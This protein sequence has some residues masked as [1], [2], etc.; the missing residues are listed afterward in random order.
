[1]NHVQRS[2][3][4]LLS[5][6]AC[7][8]LTGCSSAD[9]SSGDATGAAKVGTSGPTIAPLDLSQDLLY[10]VGNEIEVDKVELASATAAKVTLHVDAKILAWK[11]GEDGKLSTVET[12][13]KQDLQTGEGGNSQ[14]NTLWYTL[15]PHEHV[16]SVAVTY[17]KDGNAFDAYDTFKTIQLNATDRSC[18][19]PQGQSD[20]WGY[21]NLADLNGGA[22]PKGADVGAI[23]TKAAQADGFAPNTDYSDAGCNGTAA[24][25]NPKVHVSKDD[26]DRGVSAR[27]VF[28]F[29]RSDRSYYVKWVDRSYSLDGYDW[30]V[31]ADGNDLFLG[32]KFYEPNG[33]TRTFKAQVKSDGCDNAQLGG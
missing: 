33:E 32:T 20:A 30:G 14:T 2:S 9:D 6:L 26:A 23:I 25:I 7:L 21:A 17:D 19:L 11:K 18:K 24:P 16:D 15:A 10:C 31:P 13:N 4:L 5:L 22:T 27:L 3:G 29:Q 28:I 1:M 12:H 8:A